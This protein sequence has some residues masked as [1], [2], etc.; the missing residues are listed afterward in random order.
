MTFFLTHFEYYFSCRESYNARC[1]VLPEKKIW[2]I[3]VH[4]LLVVHKYMANHNVSWFS[5]FSC[6]LN[7]KILLKIE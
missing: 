4:G 1:A 3:H 6:L 7:Y 2:E 5:P